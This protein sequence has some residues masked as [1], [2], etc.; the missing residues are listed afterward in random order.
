M[1]R[2][3]ANK[4]RKMIE[5]AATSLADEKALTVPELFPHWR[6]GVEMTAGDRICGDDGYL[7]T[8]LQ[9]HTSQADWAPSV[10]P[11]LFARVLIPDPEVIPEWE[12]PSSTNPYMTGDKVR[13]N[14]S[15][16]ESAI[17]NNVWEPG[18]IGTETLWLL[19]E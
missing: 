8:V 7:Y 10:A 11:S 6:V 19:V 5:Q 18:A 4:Y 14:G 13:H 2:A 12:Q 3:M 16:W 17:D 15:V 9:T 1:N